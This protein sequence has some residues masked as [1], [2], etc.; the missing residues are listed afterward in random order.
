MTVFEYSINREFAE[1]A[2]RYE[3]RKVVDHPPAI[4]PST[5]AA[6]PAHLHRQSSEYTIRVRGVYVASLTRHWPLI[7]MRN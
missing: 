4:E 1:Q 2:R 7:V 3:R 5:S 6:S